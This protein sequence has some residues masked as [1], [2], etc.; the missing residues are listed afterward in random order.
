MAKYGPSSTPRRG[1]VIAIAAAPHLLI[2]GGVA[3]VAVAVGASWLLAAGLAAV[4]L[5]ATSWRDLRGTDG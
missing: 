2:A 4:V 1:Y 3:V 5:G